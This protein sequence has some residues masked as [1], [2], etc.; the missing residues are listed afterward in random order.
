MM[1]DGRN[2]VRI[3][4]Y[5]RISSHKDVMFKEKAALIQRY[6]AI[7]LKHDGWLYS[8]MYIDSGSSHDQLEE[9]LNRCREGAVEAIITASMNT[10]SLRRDDLYKTLSEL[11]GLG[12]DIS[13]TDEGLN[14]AGEGGETLL[15]TLAS[16]LKPVKPPKPMYTPYGIG[17]DDEAEVVRRIFSLFLAGH[18]RSPIATALNS[19]RVPPPHLDIK[20]DCSSWT[21]CDIRRILDDP[22]YVNEGI[23]TQEVW[24]HV[25]TEASRRRGNYGRRPPSPSP[26]RGLITCGV[27]GNHYTRRER[28]RSSLWLCKTYMKKGRDACPSR[29]ILETKLLALLGTDDAVDNITV[30]P[31]G[32]LTINTSTD[33]IERKWR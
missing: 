2:L 8:G 3:A 9:M 28:G 17:D 25:Q 16:F 7:I 33:S 13:F 26:L 22:I 4:A 11:K 24:E 18:G 6:N 14:T 29:C 1:T 5:G 21:Y 20:K 30:Y 32:R 12:V 15:S 31:D 23:I 27:C 10:L 19:D